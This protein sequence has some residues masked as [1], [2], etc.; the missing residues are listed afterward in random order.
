MAN[1]DFGNVPRSAE[2]QPPNSLYVFINSILSSP[3]LSPAMINTGAEIFEILESPKS[4]GIEAKA[5]ICSKNLVHFVLSGDTASYAAF[6]GVF[7]KNSGFN[8]LNALFTSG[9]QPASMGGSGAYKF[10]IQS[11]KRLRKLVI[12]SPT[13]KSSTKA[14]LQ[15][16][17]PLIDALTKEETAFGQYWAIQALA[18]L[19]EKFPLK[20]LE[21]TEKEKLKIFYNNLPKP[22]DRQYE[23]RKILSGII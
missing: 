8:V 5:I 17:K 2:T 6:I 20:D 14:D 21:E 22:S 12:I 23:L 3:S 9:S 16:L 4:N 19:A 10:A 18:R 15:G 11:P 7:V 1:C 13:Y